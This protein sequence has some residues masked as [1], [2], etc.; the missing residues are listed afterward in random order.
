MEDLPAL[1]TV[2]SK[3]TIRDAIVK[4]CTWDYSQLP[5][6]QD[7][8]CIGTV[9]LD[10]ILRWLRILDKKGTLKTEFMDWHVERFV[11]KNPRFVSPDDDILKHTKWMADRGFVL[12]GTPSK[13]EG[14][15]TNYDLVLLFKS[16]T[17][18]FLLLREIETAL[19]HVVSRKL[20]GVELKEALASVSKKD[21]LRP[22]DLNELTFND[23]RQLIMT[24]WT[25]LQ[26]LFPDRGKTDKQ[27]EAIRNLRNQVFHFRTQLLTSHLARLEKMRD[28]CVKLAEIQPAE[29]KDHP[30]R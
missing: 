28:Y 23:L 3:D 29:P 1:E 2:D 8:K 5:V 7:G 25:R 15:I 21:D 14:I 30:E 18:A 10:S 12:I 4:M 19:R 6:I 27:L 11:D 24:N 17:E 16:E 26:D 22:S 13:L 9:S 20:K